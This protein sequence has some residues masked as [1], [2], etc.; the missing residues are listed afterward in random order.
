MHYKCIYFSFLLSVEDIPLAI[1]QPNANFL[2]AVIINYILKCNWSH[3]WWLFIIQ[4]MKEYVKCELHKK[5]F[6]QVP[7]STEWACVGTKHPE[8][9]QETREK[10]FHQYQGYLEKLL[11]YFF[12]EDKKNKEYQIITNISRIIVLQQATEF[13][14]L[15]GRFQNGQASLLPY[16]NYAK[17][18]LQKLQ[19]L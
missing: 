9:W 13:I 8:D 10:T 18:I 2:R 1:F 4:H 14:K 3:S 15:V 7:L 16:V 12:R 11:L 19:R 17:N 6:I 5:Y